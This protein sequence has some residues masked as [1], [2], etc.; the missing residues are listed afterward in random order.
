MKRTLCL[1]LCVGMLFVFTGCHADLKTELQAVID[2]QVESGD[3]YTP[4]SYNKYLSALSEAK[5]VKEKS[6]VTAQQIKNAKSSLETALNELCVK[7]DKTKLEK[8]LSKAINLDK[9]KY[10]TISVGQLETAI[11]SA[12]QT[13]NDENATAS[14]V[15]IAQKSLQTKL[16]DM[17][18]ATKGVYK[19]TCSLSRLVTNHVGNDWSSGI[20]Y[21]GNAIHSG[22]TITASLN[23][24]ITIKGTVVEHDSLPD[25]GSCSV[26]IPLTG[27]EKSTQFYVR[28]NRGRY[29]GN[30]AVWELTCSA[31]LIERI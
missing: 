27:G 25:S 9:S 8:L 12:T 17:I 6:I 11:T 16:D 26:T 15:D 3:I 31:T 18:T 30:L 4:D 13:L 22:D 5:S 24:S 7:P 20:T 1:L 29:S 23:G 2:T 21:N 28:E 10:T 14:D 19:I